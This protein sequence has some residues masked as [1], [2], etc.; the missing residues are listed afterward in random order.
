M[1]HAALTG[2]IAGKGHDVGAAIDVDQVA[3][4]GRAHLHIVDGIL[5]QPHLVVD[6]LELLGDVLAGS[7]R[8][9]HEAHGIRR[10]HDL[11]VE[12]AFLARDRIG[13]R[14]LNR[15]TDIGVGGK[16]DGRERIMLE[17][18]AAPM[19]RFAH[20]HQRAAV[21]VP[22]GELAEGGETVGV[23]GAA[24]EFGHD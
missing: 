5:E 10:R 9:L 14:R 11:L 8:H 24:A 6:D 4:F 16:T 7:R 13:H 22:F 21:L 18:Q 23:G 17:R 15:R 19:R 12:V 3:E 1:F 20:Q 2:V